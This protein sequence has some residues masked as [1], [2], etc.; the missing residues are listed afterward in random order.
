MKRL[1]DFFW[2]DFSC[3]FW[4]SVS[5]A[6]FLIAL[7]LW[8]SQMVKN[9]SS[10][11]VPPPAVEEPVSAPAPAPSPPVPAKPREGSEPAEEPLKPVF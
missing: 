11:T 2:L 9:F 3:A 4:F 8:A 7:F 10:H 5:V 1:W 6:C